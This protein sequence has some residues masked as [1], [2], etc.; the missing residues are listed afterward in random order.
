MK[1]SFKYGEEPA[2]MQA[3]ASL[4]PEQE[5]KNKRID[6]LQRNLLFAADNIAFWKMC[7]EGWRSELTEL[8]E[9]NLRKDDKEKANQKKASNLSRPD[10]LWRF[11]GRLRLLASCSNIWC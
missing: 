8:V 4:T 10:N 11:S 9:Q 5:E 2:K 7:E 1:Q 3:P 6:N